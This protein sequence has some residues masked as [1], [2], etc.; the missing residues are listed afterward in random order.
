MLAAFEPHLAHVVCTQNSTAPRDAAPTRS[1]RRRARSSARTGSPWCRDLADAID[2]G[3]HA[4]RGR[5]G[6]RR[7]ARLG[8]GAGHRARSSP[9]ARRAPCCCVAGSRERRHRRPQGP[10]P[11]DTE[12]SP[13]RGM[14]AAILSLE[15]ITARPDDAGDDHHR[16]RR[17]SGTAVARR[18]SGWRW[19]ACCSPG[20]SAPSG[21]TRSG[22]VLQVAAIALGFV[23]PMMFVLGGIFALLWGIGRTSSAARSS[24]SGPRPARRT[25]PRTRTDAPPAGHSA[26]ERASAASARSSCV[27]GDATEAD[28]QAG[29]DGRAAVVGEQVDLGS[30][31]L[32]R[33]AAPGP[34]GR[35]GAARS[36]TSRRAAR[37]A[38]RTATAR[39]PPA[40]RARRTTR[41]AERT[42]SST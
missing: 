18:R 11:H 10:A 3:R 16:R 27:V 22:W 36:S 37:R 31:R 8:R 9:S 34:R 24:A 13:R 19:P 35:G 14:C 7:P 12:R 5:R 38:R 42:T 17:R 23:V 40:A 6:L 15:A 21:P 29:E 1:P 39:R 32:G 26:R 28:D 4:G 41:R 33:A 20:C 30:R 25:T 2:R